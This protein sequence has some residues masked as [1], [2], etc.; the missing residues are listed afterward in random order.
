MQ[1]P[2]EE[3][4]SQESLNLNQ[5]TNLLNGGEFF[6]YNDTIY[7]NF[8]LADYGFQL[9][10]FHSEDG[11]SALDFDPN[12]WISNIIIVDNYIY[13]K[14]FPENGVMSS[15]RTPRGSI[16]RI[17]LDGGESERLT[18]EIV[19]AF[20]IYDA[21]IYYETTNFKNR[22]STQTPPEYETR[23]YKIPL[24]GGE[25]ECILEI[26][27]RSFGV[28]TLFDDKVYVSYHD[29]VLATKDLT[30]GNIEYITIKNEAYPI[31]GILHLIPIGEELY[32]IGRITELDEK[33]DTLR[34]NA[35]LYRYNLAD[36][37]LVKLSEEFTSRFSYQ[38]GKLYFASDLWTL[39]AFDIATGETTQIAELQGWNIK[40]II[41][42][43]AF[44][45]YANRSGAKLMTVDLSSGLIV[46]EES[47]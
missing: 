11:A 26:S 3:V 27:G 6:K 8:S 24:S 25:K 35:N 39:Y 15:L 38:D 31:E 30:N 29:G 13:Y 9:S 14:D 43:Y 12:M 42:N 44:V 45:F 41:D 46:A 4:Y 18:E 40:G 28:F 34:T 33:W 17:N 21:S 47:T 22:A 5:I 7:G 20:Y 16:Y 19:S 37:E 36:G 32:F 10:S 2:K 23:I 1:P